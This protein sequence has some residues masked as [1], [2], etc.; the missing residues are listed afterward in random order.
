MDR[1][2][3]GLFSTHFKAFSLSSSKGLPSLISSQLKHLKFRVNILACSSIRDP[4][5]GGNNE[6]AVGKCLANALPC[7]SRASCA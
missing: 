2:L 7:A 3:T 5:H 1:A 6:N 4:H